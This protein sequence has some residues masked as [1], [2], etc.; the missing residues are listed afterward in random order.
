MQE[1]TVRLPAAGI[2]VDCSYRL[3]HVGITLCVL[4][5]RRGYTKIEKTLFNKEH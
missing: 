1:L 5:H 3:V 2:F 4:A